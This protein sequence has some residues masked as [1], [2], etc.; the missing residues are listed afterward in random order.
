MEGNQRISDL[1]KLIEQDENYL[2]II[3]QYSGNPSLC[4]IC[5]EPVPKGTT[6]S[7]CCS[8]HVHSRSELN[9]TV[10]KRL[11]ANRKVIRT[12]FNHDPYQRP[13]SKAESIRGISHH[14]RFWKFSHQGDEPV[15]VRFESHPHIIFG[16]QTPKLARKWIRFIE[17]STKASSGRI[18]EKNQMIILFPHLPQRMFNERY[19]FDVNNVPDEPTDLYDP[20]IDYAEG[21]DV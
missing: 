13:S 8:G 20:D 3:R 12:F 4:S 17:L 16:F 6:I 7:P 18:I 9:F 14:G 2:Q 11:S 5:G 10:H 21:D 15:L 1:T 19:G